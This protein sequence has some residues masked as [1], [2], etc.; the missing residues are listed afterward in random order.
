MQREEVK[1]CRLI[2]ENIEGDKGKGWFRY[3]NKK[4]GR[5]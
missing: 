1:N 2:K 3:R 5:P 4:L